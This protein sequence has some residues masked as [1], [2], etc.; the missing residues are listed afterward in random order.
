MTIAEIPKALSPRQHEI[1]ALASSGLSNK[2]IAR[3]LGLTEGSVKQHLH[4]AF[5]KL[6]IQ[7]REHLILQS[8]KFRQS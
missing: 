7:R 8:A 5:T 2:E 3:L 1:A 4:S 6:G